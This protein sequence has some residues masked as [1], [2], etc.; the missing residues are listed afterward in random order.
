MSFGIK[1]ESNSIGYLQIIW[2]VCETKEDLNRRQDFTIS[3]RNNTLAISLQ[4]GSTSR[5]AGRLT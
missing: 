3:L 1:D 5:S 4:L 2:Y